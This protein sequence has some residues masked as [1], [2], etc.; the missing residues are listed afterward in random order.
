M[1]SRSAP[2]DGAPADSTNG[3]RGASADGYWVW[4]PRSDLL[5][6]CGLGYMLLMPLLVGLARGLEF[7]T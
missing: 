1:R 4:G 3:A 5:L 6:G 2:R 7:R